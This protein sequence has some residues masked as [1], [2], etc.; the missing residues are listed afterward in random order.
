MI[1]NYVVLIQ[2]LT[3]SNR[4]R[5]SLSLNANVENKGL[6]SQLPLCVEIEMQFKVFINY[7][8]ENYDYSSSITS[9]LIYLCK[10][11]SRKIKT[12]QVILS[13][14]NLLKKCF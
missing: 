2:A 1:W 7:L 8:S 14:Q 12:A 4:L 9:N 6:N 5:G 11:K 10:S 13:P 3:E